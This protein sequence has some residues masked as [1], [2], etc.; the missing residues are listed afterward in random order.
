[1]SEFRH[2]KEIIPEALAKIMTKQHKTP[3]VRVKNL[4]HRIVLIKGVKFEITEIRGSD[5][6]MEGNDVDCLI[7][8][9]V[10]PTVM[11][12]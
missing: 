9:P 2:V 5:W 12:P 7:L 1:M 6:G 8:R 10:N 3:P 4:I 11:E